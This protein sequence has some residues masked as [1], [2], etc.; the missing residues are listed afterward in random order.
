MRLF[1]KEMIA[2]ESSTMYLWVWVQVNCSVDYWLPFNLQEDEG[3][4][5]AKRIYSKEVRI[6]KG[7]M[8]IIL[9]GVVEVLIL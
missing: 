7:Q 8:L 2:V 6:A 4:D 9:V 1:R 3:I 5:E